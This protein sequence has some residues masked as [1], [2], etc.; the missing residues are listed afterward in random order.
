M[1]NEIRAE[2]RRFKEKHKEDISGNLVW[3]LIDFLENWLIDH[4]MKQDKLY[5]ETISA[6]CK[7]KQNN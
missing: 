7:N 5:V 2:I 3:E 6:S 1:H 4:I